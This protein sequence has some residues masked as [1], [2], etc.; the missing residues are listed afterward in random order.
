MFE[1]EMELEKRESVLPLLLIVAF[2]VGVVGIAGY[3]VVQMRKVLPV[4]EATQVVA[5]MLGDQQ[6]PTV[7][8]Y[9]GKVNAAVEDNAQ[10]PQYKLLEKAGLITL[11]KPTGTYGQTIPVELT[12]KGDEMLKQIAGATEKKATDGAVKHVVPLAT[13]KLLLVTDVK[14]VNPSRATVEVTWAWQT[15]ALGDMFDAAGA[16]V[17]SFNTWQR[18]VLIEKN[19]A[20]FYH[21]APTK[22]VL[23]LSKSD[24]GWQIATE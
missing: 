11:G 15:N 14:M 10:D 20:A 9:T 21:G 16:Q 8:F 18:S 2:I 24:A 5:K 3:Y 17:Q 22:V 23:A 19:G 7:S 12:G 6:P 1:Q 13:R 4:D